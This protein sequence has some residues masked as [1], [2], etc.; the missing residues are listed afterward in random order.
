[1]K[2][3]NNNSRSKIGIKLE[4]IYIVM[5]FKQ[6]LGCNFFKTLKGPIHFSFLILSSPN[7]LFINKIQLKSFVYLLYF[8]AF[9]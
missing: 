6:V 3:F 9:F 1:M 8:S 7:L 2:Q 4:R 5:N